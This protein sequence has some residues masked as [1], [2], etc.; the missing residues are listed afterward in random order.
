MRFIIGAGISGLLMRLYNPDAVLVDGGKPAFSPA[1][2]IHRTEE[3]EKALKDLQLDVSP[4]DIQVIPRE[5]AEAIQDKMGSEPELGFIGRNRICELRRDFLLGAYDISLEELTKT[6]S[7]A[8]KKR[9]KSGY[10][11]GKV[12][13]I[14][15]DRITIRTKEGEESHPYEEI[16]STIHFG[17]FASIHDSW[18]YDRSNVE[19]SEMYV[20]EEEAEDLKKSSIDYTPDPST[21]LIRTL[22]NRPARKIYREY[23]TSPMDSLICRPGNPFQDTVEKVQ[24]WRFKG[25]IP[26]PPEKVVFVG[27]FATGL[28]N[29]RIQDSA[30]I[31]QGGISLARMMAEQYRFD[32]HLMRKNQTSIEERVKNLVLHIH[33]EASELLREVDWKQNAK[34]EGKTKSTSV[35]EEITDISKLLLSIANI[36]NYTPRDLYLNFMRKSDVIWDRYLDQFYG[37]IL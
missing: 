24:Q 23:K 28:P 7:D 14:T 8:L 12:T 3:I 36:F 16:I 26:P 1:V 31:A 22:K 19:F 6:I 35:I 34:K 37:G 10:I 2:F 13:R 29:W 25:S 4:H 11:E 18:S 5:P 15:K 33:A 21:G 20:S 17:A 27:R 30:F 32:Y 9:T